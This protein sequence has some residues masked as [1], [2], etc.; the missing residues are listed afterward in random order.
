MVCA[1]D[2]FTGEI[3]ECTGEALGDL[4]AVD[5]ENCGIPLPNQLEERG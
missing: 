4:P 2:G 1:G 3:V 5:E